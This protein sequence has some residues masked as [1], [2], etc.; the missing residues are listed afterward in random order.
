MN[1]GRIVEQLTVDQLRRHETSDPYSV[2]LL[3]ASEGY[4]R[5][6]ARAQVTYD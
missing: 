5:E 3:Q 6:T 2:Q 4:D 1:N